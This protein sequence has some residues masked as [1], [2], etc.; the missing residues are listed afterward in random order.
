[1]K[2]SIKENFLTDLIIVGAGPIGLACGIEAKKNNISYLII[3]KGC[4]VNS[5]FNYPTNMTFFS[6]SQ[7]I[8]LS[9]V[10]FVSH[11]IKPNRR[12]ALEYFRRVKESYALN[13][14]TYEK[15]ESVS[16]TGKYFTVITDKAIYHSKFVIIATG[17]YDNP[18]LLKVPGESLPKVKHY[19]DE[20]HPY[21]GHKVAVI[22][23]GNSAVDVALELFR[24]GADVTMIIR[25]SRIKPSVKY[26]VKPDI[27]N[28]INEGS[29]KTYFNTI[30]EK[31]TP[32]K[33]F[34][35]NKNKITGIDNDFVFSMTGYHPDFSFLKKTGIKISREM[36]PVFNRKTFES[37]VK[38]LF[39]AG[40][41]CGGINTDK[42]FIENSIKH[43]ETVIGEIAS[44]MKM[45]S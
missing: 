40:V 8:E 26:W 4:V 2:K 35:R 15:A 14:N 23:A 16:K 24:I 1:M 5:I 45:R 36:C 41:V 39:L 17:Y 25:E 21:S 10:P 11:G 6:T 18:N 43:S 38:G 42:Y 33:I 44:R 34:I 7:K 29:V 19:F 20:P 3:E 13:I 31:I 30:V 22:G 9:G 32:N 37:N 27:E 12:E 28:R